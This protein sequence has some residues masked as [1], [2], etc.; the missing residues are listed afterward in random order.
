[1]SAEDKKRRNKIEAIVLGCFAVGITASVLSGCLMIYP[2][3]AAASILLC[4]K[5]VK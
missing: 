1:M 2:L 5:F 3:S 4:N